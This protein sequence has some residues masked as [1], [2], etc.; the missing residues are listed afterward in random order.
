MDDWGFT[1]WAAECHRAWQ[2][3]SPDMQERS[4][5]VVS[6]HTCRSMAKARQAQRRRGSIPSMADAMK[7]H[8]EPDVRTPSRRPVD[9][10]EKFG[11]TYMVGL[12]SRLRAGSKGAKQVFLSVGF[13][14]Y[15]NS[16]ANA[17]VSGA[18]LYTWPDAGMMKGTLACY[19]H[20]HA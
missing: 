20:V 2:D 4:P 9:S 7:V 13:H 17:D 15:T 6:L 11:E 3:L 8:M 19:M 10:Q 12:G 5:S 14:L 1:M 18:R 16:G